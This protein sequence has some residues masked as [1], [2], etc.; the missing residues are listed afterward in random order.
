LAQIIRTGSNWN[1]LYF[2]VGPNELEINFEIPFLQIAT[3]DTLEWKFVPPFSSIPLSL[4]YHL[5]YSDNQ[6]VASE[7]ITD[8]ILAKFNAPE[9]TRPLFPENQLQS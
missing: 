4:G 5:E 8:V 6:L 7:R 1:T 2:H 9:Y 3:G